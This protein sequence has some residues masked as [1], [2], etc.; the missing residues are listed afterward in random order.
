PGLLASLDRIDLFVHDSLHTDRNLRFE[1]ARA[2]AAMDRRGAL[3]ADDVD[4]NSAFGP[5]VDAAT[6]LDG[7]VGRADDERSLFGVA[8][9]STP[10]ERRPPPA[11][12]PG[13]ARRFGGKSRVSTEAA[14]ACGT[15]SAA[16]AKLNLSR[17]ENLRPVQTG[18]VQRA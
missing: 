8:V 3:V 9:A 13:G 6:G 12:P 4:Q 1:L 10:R 14:K 7:F 18:W 5:F 17:G 16:G 15:T 2:W 11:W